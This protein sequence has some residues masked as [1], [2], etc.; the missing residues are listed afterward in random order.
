MKVYMLYVVILIIMA[1]LKCEFTHSM[2]RCSLSKKKECK[3]CDKNF[4]QFHVHA[5]NHRC[6]QTLKVNNGSNECTFEMEI[7]GYKFNPF[8]KNCNF[9]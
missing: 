2:G 6:I 4:C 8:G 9:V 3:I 1:N 7:F 5:D